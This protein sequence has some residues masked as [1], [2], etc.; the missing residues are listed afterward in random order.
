MRWWVGD[1]EAD[2]SANRLGDDGVDRKGMPRYDRVGSRPRNARARNSEILIGAIAESDAIRRDTMFCGDGLP[3]FEALPSGYTASPAMA[4]RT[5]A[6]ALGL[7]PRGFSLEAS[8][9]T[10]L[11]PSSRRSSVMGLPGS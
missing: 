5:A 9:M 10:S 11:M 2:L 7:G 3:Q 4:S 6:T 1:G 8:L